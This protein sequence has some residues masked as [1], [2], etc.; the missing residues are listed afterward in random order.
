[1]PGVQSVLAKMRSFSEAVRSGAW[2]GHTGRPITDIVNIGIG[3]SNLGPAM[4]TEALT[5][6]GRRDLAMHFVSNI[7]GTHMAETLRRLNP[8]TV[9]FIVASKT[10]TT[11]ET[12]TNAHTARR[13]LR[14]ENRQ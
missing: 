13:W 11:L 12:M 7:D 6:Y 8:E 9:L 14:G 3:G 2:T 10:F 4:V 1:M 5:P